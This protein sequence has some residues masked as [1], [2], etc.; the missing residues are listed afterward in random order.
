MSNP[1]NDLEAEI[2]QLKV[3]LANARAENIKYKKLFEVSGD[4]LSIIDLKSGKFTECNQ[5]A[6]NM[7]GVESKDNFINLKPSDI[8]PE[9]QPCGRRSEE[10]AAEHI[11]NT[12]TKGPQLFQWVHSRLDGSSFPCLVSL[13]VLNVDGDAFILAIGRDIS[14]LVETQNKLHSA[15]TDIERISYAFNEE[16]EKFEQFFSLPPA[17]IAINRLD[18]GLF[19]YV[20]KELSRFSGY[21]KDELNQMDY[22]KLTPKK[23]EE[24]EKQTVFDLK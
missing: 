11:E 6:I 9:Y 20:N 24:Q 5:A 17:G 7:H 19:E 8:S 18:N 13:T 22:W 4:A 12:L 23:Y 15:S 2:D 14:E 16:K 3:Q 10:I 21:D 1:T